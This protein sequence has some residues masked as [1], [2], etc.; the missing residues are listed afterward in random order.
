MSTAPVR[1]SN[2]ASGGTDTRTRDPIDQPGAL[3]NETWLTLQTRQAQRLIH[4]RRAE[5]DKAAIIGLT[6]FSVLVRQTW[7]GARAGDPYADWWLLKIHDALEQSRQ[8]IEIIQRTVAARLSSIAG[9]DI[10]SACS[11][12][13]VRVPLQFSHA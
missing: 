11:L 1:D 12:E 2:P 13:P 6:R 7:T 4:G 8:D 5:H 3:R 9:V 10:A